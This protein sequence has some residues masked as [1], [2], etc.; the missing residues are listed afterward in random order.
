MAAPWATQSKT[1]KAGAIHFS[2]RARRF[3]GAGRLGQPVPIARETAVHQSLAISQRN[4][5]ESASCIRG[6][7]VK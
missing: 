4:R 2:N 1:I 5:V 3:C 7:R 6:V